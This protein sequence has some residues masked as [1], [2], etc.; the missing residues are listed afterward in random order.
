MNKLA[1]LKSVFELYLDKQVYHKEPRNLYA[2][3]K[4]TLENGGKRIRPLLVLL[5]AQSFGQSI[6]KALP[7]AA[8]IEIFHNF[9][10]LHDD[11]MDAAPLRRGKPTVHQKWDE[12]IAILSGDTMLVLAYKMLEVYDAAIYK[13]LNVLLNQTAVEVCEGQQMDMDFETRQDVSIQEYIEMIKL[14]T[15]VLLGAA[16]K[17]GG[18][19]AGAPEADLNKISDF[20]IKLGL[21]FQ[22]Q[23]DYLDT[24]GD[25]QTF[26]KRIGGD[27]L[28]R[29]KT[30]LYITALQKASKEDR[31]ILLHLYQSHNIAGEK[32]FVE[33]VVQLFKKYQVDKLTKAKINYYT[34]EAL[35][36][37]SQTGLSEK[38]K[39]FWK[40]FA[41]NLMHRNS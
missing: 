13:Q 39:Q 26:G 2:P 40:T 37:L 30:F 11:I 38:Q 3:I 4:Y 28:D 35:T 6:D 19:V 20:G 1:D 10:L 41:Y 27:I 25:S 16:L 34:E 33:K 9:T 7:A 8:A 17:F 18:I 15:A 21:A 32:D 29:K 5:S 22:I 12:N 31:E 36:A 24:F 14:K 23:D